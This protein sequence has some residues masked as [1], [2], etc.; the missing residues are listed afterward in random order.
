MSILVQHARIYGQEAVQMAKLFRAAG[1]KRNGKRNQ[2]GVVKVSLLFL[3]FVFPVFI[4]IWFHLPLY[5][6]HAAI[7]IHGLT[8]EALNEAVEEHLAQTDTSTWLITRSLPSG[9]QMTYLDLPGVSSFQT[10][11]VDE[12]NQRLIQLSAMTVRLPLGSVMGFPFWLA[13]GPTVNV[14]F[15]L[16]GP[17]QGK[18][19]VSD[20]AAGKSTSHAVYI[21]LN[22][23]V[24]IVGPAAQSIDSRQ[25]VDANRVFSCFFTLIRQDIDGCRRIIN[26]IQLYAGG[27]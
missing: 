25:G 16:Q 2:L 12:A 18:L 19:N 22:A 21:T 17:V 13:G 15:Q 4:F 11:V 24:H 10:E 8:A 7:T 20:E 1:V 26:S 23:R 5:R 6:A 27:L 9:Q 14:R 3:C